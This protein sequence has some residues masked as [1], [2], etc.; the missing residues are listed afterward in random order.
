MIFAQS[1]YTFA[2]PRLGAAT[3]IALKSA[4][5]AGISVVNTEGWLPLI[6]DGYCLHE[7]VL[8][9]LNIVKK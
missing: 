9:P 2:F 1:P 7:A 8:N 6:N 3:A 4:R 5:S